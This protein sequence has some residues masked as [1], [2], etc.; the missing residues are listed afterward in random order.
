M[1]WNLRNTLINSVPKFTLKCI[2]GG[3]IDIS[4]GTGSYVKVII[5]W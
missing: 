2:E 1:K 3:Q 4:E 5:G